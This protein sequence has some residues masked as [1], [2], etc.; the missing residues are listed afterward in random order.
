VD[1]DIDRST[2]GRGGL[3]RVPAHLTRLYGRDDAV[4]E[5][6]RLAGAARLLTLTGAG[7]S[8]KTRLAVEVVR[9]LVDGYTDGVWFVALSPLEDGRLLTHAVANVLD[10][11]E[12][13][14]QPLLATLVASLGDSR[15]L[16]VL[17]N[18]EHIVDSCAILAE[19]LLGSCPGVR[20]IATSRE[21]LRIPGEV[22]WRVPSLDVPDPD[23]VR[24]WQALLDYGA[25][26]LFVDR[27]RA[28][29]SC[30]EPSEAT[31]VDAARICGRLDGIPL[32]IEL[33]AACVPVLTTGEIL[34]RLRD[35]LA[36]LTRGPRTA[37]GRQRTLRATID[38][39]YDL[40][41]S[42][43]RAM[44]ARLSVFA[45]GFRLEAAEM[46]WA[47]AGRSAPAIEVV[48]RLVD[49][50][51]L[52]RRADRYEMAETIR[53]YGR[54]RL[55][56]AGELDEA[57]DQ[58]L[59]YCLAIGEEAEPRLRGTD[60]ARWLRRLDAEHGNLRAA[61]DWA[62]AR[63]PDR[64][65]R[66][67]TAA[68]GFWY[69]RGHMGEGCSWLRRG[70]AHAMDVPT[71]LRALNLL[72]WLA[73]RSGDLAAAESALRDCL[74]LED[75]AAMGECAAEVR[76]NLG[77][78]ACWR[79]DLVTARRHLEESADLSRRLDDEHSLAHALFN[80][81]LVAHL[82]GQAGDPSPLIDSLEI[83]QRIGDRPGTALALG[84]L[85]C[86]A[87]EKGDVAG[88]AAS[89]G[90]AMRITRD[91]GD[92]VNVLFGLE[93]F[94][95]LAA[96]RADYRRAITLAGAA[97]ALR[98]SVG[99]ITFSLWKARLDGVL[100]LARRI[101]VPEAADAAWT[102]GRALGLAD[103]ID[104]ALG[105]PGAAPATGA[106][107]LSRRENEIAALVASGLTNREIAERLYIAP[108]TV[109]THVANV[110]NKLGVTNRSLVA[111]W[112]VERRRPPAE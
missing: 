80:L 62:L 59:R 111:A 2:S 18:C 49:R 17:D 84:L 76:N 55:V 69:L 28:A 105:E 8:G 30:F 13:P 95:L 110:M 81:S 67:A 106:G 77:L 21:A 94:A 10:V 107:T 104:L 3:H 42:D 60:I 93:A 52:Y 54:E 39:S 14:D 57:R 33:A 66:L 98:E 88:A 11:P 50:S 37:A 61:L 31:M 7:G 56:E 85:G 63:E 97:D 58:H 68:G 51:L 90:E 23:A 92:R 91:L 19:R 112:V 16:I 48:G 32:A 22:A 27:A 6:R 45:G 25:V 35:S 70:L 87:I 29:D 99:A 72:G 100:D 40:L 65:L 44:L 82:S 46:V 9:G 34:E 5:V 109:E 102:E 74:D 43:E 96:R 53:Q 73:L 24:P 15:R 101:V 20:I 79:G 36:L 86:V 71:R 1:V 64:A 38:W 103:A 4:E 83:L 108:R 41:G 47:A 26:A 78:L 89:L 75:R 12:Q